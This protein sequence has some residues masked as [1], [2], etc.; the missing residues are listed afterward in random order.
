[1]NWLNGFSLR[2]KLLLI[3]CVGILGFVLIIATNLS[4]G[5]KTGH[6]LEQIRDLYYPEL[7]SSQS[8]IV[9]VNR[10]AELLNS[11][12]VAGDL[13]LIAAAKEEAGNVRQTIQQITEL[14]KGQDTQTIN[15]INRLFEQYFSTAKDLSE[16]IISGNAD[17]S[18]VNNDVQSMGESQKRLVAEMEAF[19]DAAFSQFSASIQDSIAATQSSKFIGIFITVAVTL[20]LVVTAVFITNSI[21]NKINSV[22]ASLR[23]M[24]TGDGDLTRRITKDS[25]DEIGQ[26][27]SG[28]NQF[29]EK[30]QGIIKDIVVS[31]QPLSNMSQELTG[32]AHSSRKSIELQLSSASEVTHSMQEMFSSLSENATNTAGAAEAATYTNEQAQSGQSI[33]RDAIH[34][35]DDLVKE[36]AKAGDFISQLEKDSANVGTILDVIQNIASQTNLLALNAAIEAARAGEHGRGFAVVADEVRTLAQRTQESTEEIHNVIEQLQKTARSVSAIMEAGQQKA[37]ASMSKANDAGKSLEAITQRVAEI[38]SMNT[39]IAAA[40]EQ[41]QQTTKNMQGVVSEIRGSAE[42]AAQGSAKVAD[43]TDDLVRIT[44]QLEAVSRQFRV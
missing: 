16:N 10:I 24:A 17:F 23:D 18:T 29:V 44:Q 26:L 4:A 19:R 37:T 1:M 43:T 38:N 6:T 20:L 2:Q 11:A 21:T 42:K 3:P 8:L 36:V 30:L 31:L 13:E 9:R 33:V 40:T 12:V 41:Q 32:L 7:S 22:S 27:I 5:A 35:I 15:Q 39:Q 34:T 14:M 28:F 25:D